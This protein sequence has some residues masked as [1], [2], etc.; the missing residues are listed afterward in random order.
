MPINHVS[1]PVSDLETAFPVYLAAL[2]PLKYKVFK[3]YPH[4]IVGLETGGI[5]EVWLFQA[6]E[7][8]DLKVVPAKVHLALGAPTRAVVRQFHEAAL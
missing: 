3:N 8:A 2:K 1:L 6:S 4:K 7:Q 5:P